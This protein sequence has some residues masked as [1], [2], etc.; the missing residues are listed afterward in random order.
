MKRR[1]GFTLVEVL[2]TSIISAITVGSMAMV[3]NFSATRTA[4]AFANN[5]A[6][7]QMQTLSRELDDTISRATSSTVITVGGS[8]GLK[9][10]MP[11]TEADTDG[12]GTNDSYSPVS[13]AGGAPKWGTGKRVWFYMSNATGNFLTPGTIL[14]KAER[15][16]DAYPTGANTDAS[17]TYISGS[18]IPRFGLIDTITWA[19]N[20]T[21][22]TVTY[23]VR[24]N[25]LARGDRKSA[26]AYT[27]DSARAQVV[28]LTRT[29][30]NENWRQ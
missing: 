15:N 8:V 19:T 25:S 20:A 28:N 5:S 11:A 24:A 27:T 30:L 14:W 16:D 9:S 4:M 3:Y 2:L 26:T 18:S 7:I 10:V 21:D 22:K 1:A 13:M 23:T 17:F 29:V 12:D 6:T